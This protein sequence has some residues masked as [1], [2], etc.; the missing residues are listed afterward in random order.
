MNPKQLIWA[1]EDRVLWHCL[2]ANVMAQ[3]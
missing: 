1:S 3:H 2:V